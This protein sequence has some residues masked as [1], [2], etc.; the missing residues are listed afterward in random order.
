VA[1]EYDESVT[2][3][4][5]RLAPTHHPALVKEMR[6]QARSGALMK[7]ECPVVAK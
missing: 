4:P 3:S 1:P 2:V 7:P 6:M 5:V